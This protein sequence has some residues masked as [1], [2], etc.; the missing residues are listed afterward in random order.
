MGAGLSGLVCAIML[1]KNGIHPTIFE[2]RSQAG[3]RFINGEIFL[4]SLSKPVSDA[5]AYFA[6]TYGIYLQPTSH[7]KN[8]VLY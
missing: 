3:D 2:K 4:S 1:E 7:I 6:D 8:L 5:I